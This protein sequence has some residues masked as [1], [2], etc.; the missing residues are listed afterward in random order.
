MRTP[1][2]SYL[3]TDLY[4]LQFLPIVEMNSIVYLSQNM[5]ILKK[6]NKTDAALK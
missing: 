4:I 5:S 1:F 6:H 3:K 2:N